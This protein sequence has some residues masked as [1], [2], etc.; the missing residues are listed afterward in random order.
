[1]GWWTIQTMKMKTRRTRRRSSLQGNDPVWDLKECPAPSLYWWTWILPFY[2]PP[3]VSFV[4][5][6]CHLSVT[7]LVLLRRRWL[8]PTLLNYSQT[9]SSFPWKQVE[10][11]SFPRKPER[12]TTLLLTPPDVLQSNAHPCLVSSA[13]KLGSSQT[14]W[15]PHGPTFVVFCS[16][17]LIATGTRKR[18]HYNS[19][20]PS[21]FLSPVRKPEHSQRRISRPVRLAGLAV[22]ALDLAEHASELFGNG[23]VWA[24]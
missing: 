14:A 11:P 6:L 19:K 22:V 12:H 20:P 10:T 7:V 4:L 3:A 2:A 17:L 18:L 9:P 8:T 1:M 24:T 23:W 21:F 16:A 15:L 5:G 13:F